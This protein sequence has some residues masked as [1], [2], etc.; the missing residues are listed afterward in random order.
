MLA[1]NEGSERGLPRK[2]DLGREAG[3]SLAVEWL[4]IRLPMQGKPVRPLVLEDPTCLGVT[5]SMSLNDCAL[6]P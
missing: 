2:E 6:T 5:K 1:G 3:T 4:G